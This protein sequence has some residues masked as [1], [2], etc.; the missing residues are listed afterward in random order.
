[1]AIGRPPAN[2]DDLLVQNERYLESL[3]RRDDYRPNAIHRFVASSAA[4]TL[5]VSALS[6]ISQ[7]P[8]N[9]AL[10]RPTRAETPTNTNSR[11]NASINFAPSSANVR[12]P[13]S[14]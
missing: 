11:S 6:L 3:R 2:H 7:L 5:A 12:S 4:N 1:M 8:V 9:N 14:A 13:R 10:S